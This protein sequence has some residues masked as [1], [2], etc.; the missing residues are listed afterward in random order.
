MA[1]EA[2]LVML[3]QEASLDWLDQKEIKEDLAL[4]I[5]DQE[6]DRATEAI[7]E[8]VVLVAAEETVVRK[9]VL[10]IKGLQGNL[11]SQ[12]LRVNLAQEVREERAAVTEILALREILVSQNATS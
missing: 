12:G 7:R 10:E 5:P 9:V 8:T 1:P 4:A 3:D 11:A 2:I 6:E